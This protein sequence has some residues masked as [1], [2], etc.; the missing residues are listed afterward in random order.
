LTQKGNT[1]PN[2]VTVACNLVDAYRT[3]FNNLITNLD[4]IKQMKLS[5]SVSLV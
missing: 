5:S 3:I 1:V 2:I 4:S